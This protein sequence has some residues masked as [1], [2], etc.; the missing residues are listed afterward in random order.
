VNLDRCRYHAGPIG[1]AFAKKGCKVKLTPLHIAL[2]VNNGDLSIELI[3][4]A[5]TQGVEEREE[6][7]WKGTLPLTLPAD[8]TSG[9]NEQQNGLAKDIAAMAN[10][11]GGL[12]VYGVNE[13]GRPNA[14]SKI[15]SVGTRDEVTMRNIRW[16][17]FNLI[18]PPVTGLSFQWLTARDSDESVLVLEVARSAEAPHLVRPKKQP[19]GTG[20]WFAVPYRHGP[21][22]EWMPE[23]MIESAYRDRFANR[24]QREQDLRELHADLVVTAT[25]LALNSS[26]VAVARRRI[27]CLRANR[28]W[29]SRR[30]PESSIK[31]GTRR[32]I[33]TSIR[34]LQPTTC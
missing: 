5:C 17:A 20:F 31:R 6:L 30:L 3:R 7:D 29:T 24:R 32:G 18:H 21:D 16:V 4:E 27:L 12:L 10:T 25:S 19:H 23:R 13:T 1:V 22:T 11:N 28:G 8:N 9:R 15:V 34:W 33:T 14:A 2:G 26:V